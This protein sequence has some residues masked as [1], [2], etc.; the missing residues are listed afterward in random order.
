M[1]RKTGKLFLIFGMIICILFGTGCGEGYKVPPTLA[2]LHFKIELSKTFN[3]DDPIEILIKFGHKNNSNSLADQPNTALLLVHDVTNGDK[4][5][6]LSE[7]IAG[8][9]I[10]E[11]K[12]FFDS[13]YM[14]KKE[15]SDD[16]TYY[17][18]YNHSA[19]AIIPK[20]FFTNNSGCLKL[21]FYKFDLDDS[22]N[23]S[24]KSV[25]GY[26]FLTYER[27][28]DMIHINLGEIIYDNSF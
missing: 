7:L 25:G 9:K 12:S 5:F 23:I 24:N 13:K 10:L 3:I 18:V 19:K 4:E 16:G 2:T 6:T 20:S 14:L 8:E 21:S 28:D 17:Y 26:C 15:K 11:I 22:G 1:M 27:A